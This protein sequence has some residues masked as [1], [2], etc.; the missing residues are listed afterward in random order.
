[1]P[2]VTI[3]GVFSQR[4]AI[5]IVCLELAHALAKRRSISLFPIDGRPVA[6]LHAESLSDLFVDRPDPTTLAIVHGF[7]G[8]YLS[9]TSKHR[10][11]IGGFVA[12]GFP[13]GALY[14][15]RAKVQTSAAY[16]PSE[17]SRRA[18]VASG[19]DR[20]TAIVPHGV[21]PE[22]TPRRKA[23]TLGDRFEIAFNCHS[24][25]VYNRK[26]VLEAFRAVDRFEGRVR[27]TVKTHPGHEAIARGF[28]KTSGASPE[29]VV[30]DF[31]ANLSVPELC[32][33]VHGFDAVL[34]PSRCEGAGMVGKEV[35]AAGV[36]LIATF[37]TGHADYLPA[38]GAVKVETSRPW[39]SAQ[40]FGTS[41]L[42]ARYPDVTVD[43]VE[44]AISRAIDDYPAL[45]RAARAGAETFATSHQW[46]G[47]AANLDRFLVSVATGR[48]K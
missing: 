29:N 37:D 19:Y 17:W 13:V 24:I 27:L 41:R 21:S 15:H 20:P 26:A 33:W 8:Q 39:V 2:S 5:P 1:M 10:F 3:Y 31:R 16:F 25:E 9:Q 18:Y 47:F 38:P 44:A 11:T 22:F 34:A 35:L 40:A 32:A 7:P 43:A 36:P 4:N 6:A 23:R 46:D 12:D 14:A 48:T 45:E 30:F 28:L 42:E